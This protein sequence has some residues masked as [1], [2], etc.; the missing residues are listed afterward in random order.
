MEGA[1]ECLVVGPMKPDRHRRCA[2]A[3]AQ[4]FCGR[5]CLY[6][7]QSMCSQGEVLQEKDH[8][9]YKPIFLNITNESEINT[10][11]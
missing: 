3:S 6:C 5:K 7:L 10:P 9:L 2:E 11:L 4:N 1:R 8:K